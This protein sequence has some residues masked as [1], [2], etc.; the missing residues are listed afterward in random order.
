MVKPRH[1]VNGLWPLYKP[2][3]NP[4]GQVA[5][6]I[7]PHFQSGRSRGLVDPIGQVAIGIQPHFQS[8]RGRGLVDMAKPRHRVNGVMA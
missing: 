7:Q 3:F 2:S 1:R 5:V 8:G 6:E 4:I